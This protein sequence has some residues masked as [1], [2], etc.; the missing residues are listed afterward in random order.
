MPPEG[1]S[2]IDELLER[3][4][5]RL[6]RVTPQGAAKEMAAGALLVDIRNSEQRA[7]DGEIPGAIVIDRT[8]LEW[9]LDPTSADRIPEA[10][11]PHAPVILIC[12]EGYSSSLAAAT[13]QQLGLRNATDLTGGIQAWIRAGLPVEPPAVERT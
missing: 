12:N 8:V 2:R 4:R 3:A 5:R 7:A 11:D 10:S 9:R 1:G 13:L 6:V